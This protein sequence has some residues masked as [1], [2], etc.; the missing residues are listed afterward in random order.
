MTKTNSTGKYFANYFRFKLIN[1]KSILFFSALLGLLSFLQYS[2]V[3]LI[4]AAVK[5]NDYQL[6]YA[7]LEV[8]EVLW[9]LSVIATAGV[10][11][12]TALM[13]F[14]FFLK[15][16]KTDMLGSLPITHRQRFW[17]DFISGYI[18]S[19]APFAVLSGLSIAVM[20]IAESF[21]KTT[22]Y[23]GYYACFV[24]TIFFVLSMIYAI[25]V[26]AASVGGRTIGALACAAITI[27][28]SITLI[29]GA[30]G[31]VVRNITG[32][33]YE[34]IENRLSNLTPSIAVLKDDFSLLEFIS[35]SPCR[36]LSNID[37]AQETD[38]EKSVMERFDNEYRKSVKESA[39]AQMPNAIVW[40]A[41]IAALAAA[42]FYLTKY[43]KAERTGGAFGH[44]YGYY[45]VLA[46][47]VI[48][49]ASAIA[50]ELMEVDYVWFL[51]TLVIISVVVFLI[52]EIS[53]R[54]GWKNFGIGAAV[55]AGCAAITL[56]ITGI[57]RGTGAFGLRYKLPEAEDIVL[58]E[59]NNYKFDSSEDIAKLRRNH[60]DF[61][62][63]YGDMLKTSDM[64][65]YS[66]KYT[67]K[68]GDVFERNYGVIWSGYD[69]YNECTDALYNIPTSLNGFTEQLLANFDI[70]KLASYEIDIK[71]IYGDIAIK[72][73]KLL[74]FVEI[75]G[76]DY[77]L[78]NADSKIIG[79]AYFRFGNNNNQIDL[80]IYDNFSKTIGFLN[81]EEN[82]IVPENDDETVCYNFQ[83]G[84]NGLILVVNVTKGDLESARVKELLSL[85]SE[86]TTN[87][88][89]EIFIECTD[90]ISNLY[91][92]KE[93]EARAIRLMWEL[94]EEKAARSETEI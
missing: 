12:F 55:L 6:N 37:P 62:N 51:V 31:F 23:T 20:A 61:L 36:I 56:G 58:A 11:I 79:N 5:S 69:E 13:S 46:G 28:A 57:I 1:G 84:R 42:A 63:D 45:A 67:L 21:M 26:F 72:P 39:V 41:E 10:V 44:K 33:P 94:F 19:A 65:G 77:A 38:T 43:R 54:R 32:K 7:V 17:G 3:T 18:L 52:F 9:L 59:C 89:G 35:S 86:D 15:K 92:P 34:D 90:R 29:S 75:L 91:V 49:I 53:M 88:R 76:K 93:N 4:C 2:V 74:E 73:E 83:Y 80:D 60:L 27:V 64:Y 70:E 68:N 87:I 25:G 82:I 22:A 66:I 24:V 81:S 71:G 47:S 14:D 40:T 48:L 30:C 78:K 8:S 16:H 85:L 50:K